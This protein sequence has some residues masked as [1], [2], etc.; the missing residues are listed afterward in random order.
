MSKV[1]PYNFPEGAEKPTPDHDDRLV[2]MGDLREIVTRMTKGIAELP[3]RTW[4]FKRG[5]I[6][7]WL[8]EILDETQKISFKKGSQ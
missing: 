8:E 3:D 7:G 6:L 5:E 1:D 4:G 2:R